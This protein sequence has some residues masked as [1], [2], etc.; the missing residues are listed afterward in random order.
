MNEKKIIVIKGGRL[1]DGTGAAPIENAVVIIE[2][3]KIR[4]AGRDVEFPQQAEV[5]DATGKTVMPGLID[6]HI[7]HAGVPGHVT[8]GRIIRPRELCLIK[9]IGD[10]KKLLNAGFTTVR[11]VGGSNGMNAVFLKKAVAEG[12]LTGLPRIVAAGYTLSQTFGHGDTHYFPPE[13]CDART[14][15]HPATAGQMLICDGVDECIKATRYA[16]RQGGDFIKVST[17]GGVSSERDKPSEVQFNLDEIRAIV[18]AAAQVGKF[19]A[20]HSQNSAGSKNAILG[21]IKTIEHANETSDEVIGLALEH[22]AIFVSTLAVALDMMENG[23]KLVGPWGVEKARGQWALMVDSYKRI[24]KSGAILAVGTDAG[25]TQTL[26]LGKN[27]VELELLV[28]HCDFTPMDA[29]VAATRYGAMA[30]FMEKET[31]TIEAGKLADIIVVDGNP[32]DD[33]GILQDQEKIQV[34]LLEGRI[35]I[36]RRK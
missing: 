27:A 17:T 18:A 32:L 31:G 7:H 30:C 23:E 1:I 13:C 22:G 34:V 35:E 5:I 24:R 16:M 28:K 11:D 33:I 2:G 26:S 21:G 12:S 4:S 14:S 19:V 10:S 29:I 3:N 15:R 25:V 20:S 6:A 9:S 36:D 8:M